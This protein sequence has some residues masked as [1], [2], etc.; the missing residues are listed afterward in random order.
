MMDIRKLLKKKSFIYGVCGAAAIAIA[1]IVA[2]QNHTPTFPEYIDNLEEQIDHPDPWKDEAQV[3]TKTQKTTTKKKVNLTKASTRTYT[4]NLGT[5]TTT[6]TKNT[7]TSTANIKTETKVAVKTTEKY[8]K[9]KKVKEVTTQTTTTVTTMTQQKAVEKTTTAQNVNQSAA[10]QSSS[11]S[12]GGNAS[13]RSEAP[14]MDTR[15][16]S[17]FE[18]LGF[19]IVIDPT[20]AMGEGYFNAKNRTITMTKAKTNHVYH[21]LGH[22]LA[23]IA[24]NVDTSSSF[25]SIYNDEKGSFKGTYRAYASGSSSEFFAE[26]VREYILHRGDFKSW[27]PKAYEAVEAAMNKITTNQVASVQKTYGKIW[28][29]YS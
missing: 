6:T 21:E 1:C 28:A 2:Y 18:T 24:G 4:K 7:S 23:F 29:S 22:F 8:T 16:L 17:A 12:S 9:G 14:L 15:I 11:S 27:C 5:K 20:F 26:C 10:S 25:K 3:E 19:K 13:V